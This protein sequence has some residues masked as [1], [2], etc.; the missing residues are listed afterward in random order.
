MGHVE[1]LGPAES[2]GNVVGGTGG[3]QTLKG[4]NH[5]PNQEVWHF[6][7]SAEENQKCF[8]DR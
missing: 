2:V 7:Q 8:L 5:T 3:A 6:I 4:K 1:P